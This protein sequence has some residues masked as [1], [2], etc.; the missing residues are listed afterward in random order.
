MERFSRQGAQKSA[1]SAT[2]R[3]APAA[4]QSTPSSSAA[5]SFDTPSL[6]SKILVIT[7]IF[8]SIA[9]TGTILA[10]AMSSLT[11]NNLVKDDQYQA[12]FLDN[13]QVYF[14]KLSGARGDYVRLTDIYYLQV[15]Q[16][17]QP[18]QTDANGNPVTSQNVS[19]AKL[20][21]ELHGPEDEMFINEDR[22]VFWENLKA[23]GTVTE[24]IIRFRN[25]EQPEAT[26]PGAGA[27]AETP[28]PA[29]TAPA[30]T[31]AGSDTDGTD[32]V[33]VETDDATETP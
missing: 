10:G 11:N 32:T 18:G 20:G 27:G 16:Q 31:D 2:P 6:S 33:P 24:S 9:V 28:A 15:E 12:V 1:A 13:G 4:A 29:G 3:T 19:L 25:G 17:I 21:N 22:I 5:S 30:G 8:A 7:L 23:D 26:T 14:G